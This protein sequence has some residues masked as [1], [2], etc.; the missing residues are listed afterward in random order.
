MANDKKKNLLSKSPKT[1]ERNKQIEP[2][3]SF[4]RNS[5]FAAVEEEPKTTVRNK[6]AEKSTTTRLSYRNKDRI[7]ALVT[8]KGLNSVD[9]L[10]DVLIDEHEATLTS[11]EKRELRTIVAIYQKKRK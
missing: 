2:S 8:L 11:D 10:L 6:I 7:N 9:E 5:I 3:S 1:I 4:S